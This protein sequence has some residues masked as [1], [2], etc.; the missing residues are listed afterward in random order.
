MD[1]TTFKTTQYI[2]EILSA[3]GW[4]MDVGVINEKMGNYFEM[5][6]ANFSILSPQQQ[7]DS[8][9]LGQ[10]LNYNFSINQ[11]PLTHTDLCTIL[12]HLSDSNY[13]DT[14]LFSLYRSTEHFNTVYCSFYYSD[15]QEI[16]ASQTYSFQFWSL[17]SLEPVQNGRGER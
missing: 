12:T 13:V 10:L 14:E 15:V 9:E 7:A 16:G 11:Y 6:L 8:L 5:T 2:V 17:L 4:N 3:I 1:L